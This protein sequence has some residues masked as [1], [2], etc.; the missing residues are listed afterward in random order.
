MN[1][2]ERANYPGPTSPYYKMELEQIRQRNYPYYER[3]K[4]VG[5]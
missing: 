2:E 5:E 1:Y 4:A 3:I